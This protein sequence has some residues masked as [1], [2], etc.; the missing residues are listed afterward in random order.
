MRLY[1]RDLQKA[2]ALYG[3]SGLNIDDIVSGS[4]VDRTAVAKAMIECDAVIHAAAATPGQTTSP[5]QLF[6]VNVE[7]VRS[8]I[9]SACE[10]NIRRIVYVSSVT[11]IFRPGCTDLSADSPVVSSKHP[12]GQSKAEAER[13]IRSLQEQCFP[14]KTV[15]PGGVIGP[16]D[17]AV[18]ATLAS[19][20]Y[21]LTQGFKITSGGTQQIDVR[22]LAL[23]IVRLLELDDPQPRRY[24]TVGHY[25]EWNRFAQLLENV[26][27]KPLVK[28][29]VPGWF[30]RFIGHLYDV[31]RKVMKVESPISAET[32]SYATQ[33]PKLLND[34]VVSR[35]GIQ[36]T[37]PE[38]T[39]TDTIRWLLASGLM[40]SSVA[41][42]LASSK[43]L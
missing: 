35:L 34:P 27:G 26:T 9:G 14:V 23:I 32:M 19:L 7:G 22:D 2:R 4:L 15:Y 24:L 29:H 30:L 8:V 20:L 11:A 42:S 21:R 39:Y 10:Q 3:K 43:T 6:Q 18:S 1:V 37:A 33:W 17:P 38:K 12:Y 13:Y 5:D 25:Y 41:P 31:Q 40:S 28:Q 16:D 36:L